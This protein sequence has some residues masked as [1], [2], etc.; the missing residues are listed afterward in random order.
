MWTNNWII[1]VTIIK[2]KME[3]NPFEWRR[4]VGL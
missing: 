1:I 4:N 3:K 2:W